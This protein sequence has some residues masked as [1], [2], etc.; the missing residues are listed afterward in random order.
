MKHREDGEADHAV[1]AAA[2]AAEDDL[3][4]SNLEHLDKPPSGV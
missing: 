1:Q 2:H 4:Q 3:A